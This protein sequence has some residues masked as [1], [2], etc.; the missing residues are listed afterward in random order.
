VPA[1]SPTDAGSATVEL[2]LLAPLLA[3]MVL[4]AMHLSE[5]GEVHLRQQELARFAAWEMTAHALSD[6]DGA[7]HDRRFAAARAE[8]LDEATR[9]VRD[10]PELAFRG[11]AT[12]VRLARP[13]E[14]RA[15]S[16]ETGAEMPRG[17]GGV[18]KVLGVLG[19]SFDA[20]LGD[21]YG[22]DVKGAMVEASVSL[23]VED[24]LLAHAS[25]PL[26]GPLLPERL[27]VVEL[28]PSRLR[29]GIDTFSVDDGRDVD[30]PGGDAGKGYR[31][32][33]QVQRMHLFAHARRQLL[34][35]ADVAVRAVE[36][37][38]PLRF[39]TEAQ[40][41]SQ[42]Y[43]DPRDDPSRASCRSRRPEVVTGAWRNG[44]GSGYGGPTPPDGMSAEK[45]FDT[46]PLQSWGVAR[47]Y[48]ADESY[49]TLAARRDRFLGC[50]AG[51]KD[52]DCAGP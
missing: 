3:A 14:L 23:R 20:V 24:R 17:S 33:K 27:R 10:R 2:A 12:E 5:L 26:V 48:D 25:L 35:G 42:N 47:G 22:F 1:R 37:M 6:L 38:L 7:Q 40:V 4:Y 29:L 13:I 34:G 41:V 18:E 16:L 28:A 19:R 31:F 52:G 51:S 21:L 8:V 46:L 43:S 49:A 30:L 36:A 9:R 50:R 39:I 15:R 45:C 32:W 44:D 11:V